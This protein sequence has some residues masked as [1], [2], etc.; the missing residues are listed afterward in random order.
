MSRNAHKQNV[1][2]IDYFCTHAAHLEAECRQNWVMRNKNTASLDALISVCKS[3]DCALEI[4]DAKPDDDVLIQMTLCEQHAGRYGRDCIMHALQKWYFDW[5]PDWEIARVNKAHS[6]Y[7]ELVGTYTG[8]RVGCD[9]V[10]N[11]E[12]STENERMCQR[13]VVEYQDPKNCPNQH[14]N[15]RSSRKWK[16]PNIE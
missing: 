5:P 15:R 11:C 4:L 14:R 10:G 12:G 13:F 2:D 6:R 7:P 3:D 9:Q 8:A 16:K 1:E